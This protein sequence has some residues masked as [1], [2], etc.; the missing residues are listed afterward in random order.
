MHKRYNFELIENDPNFKSFST[1]P[2]SLNQND[3]C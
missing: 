2:S 3:E 1:I